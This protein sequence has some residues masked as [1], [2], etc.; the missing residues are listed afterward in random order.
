M[1]QLNIGFGQGPATLF[2]GCGRYA[3]M[4]PP[5]P[6]SAVGSSPLTPTWPDPIPLTTFTQ[7]TFGTY[8]LTATGGVMP[9]T[10]TLDAGFTLPAGLS[11]NPATGVIS[12][13]PTTPV[14]LAAESFA[15]TDSSS[16]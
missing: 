7:G 13:T 5:L 14:N 16:P 3:I 11:L 10:F 1:P 15:V 12:G 9:Y 4:A 2:A 6:L 8:T